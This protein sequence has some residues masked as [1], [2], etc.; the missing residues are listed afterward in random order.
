MK[1]PDGVNL[2]TYL[3]YK[4]NKDQDPRRKLKSE[5]FNWN[6]NHPK[7]LITLCIEEIAGKW[8]GKISLCT[9]LFSNIEKGYGYTLTFRSF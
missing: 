8:M 1:F 2:S 6:I 3:A 9:Y 7:S 5:F 4:P